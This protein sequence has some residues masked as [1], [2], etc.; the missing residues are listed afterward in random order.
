M[1]VAQTICGIFVGRALPGP[2][3]E[4]PCRE[5]LG[6]CVATQGGIVDV[7]A[8]YALE[9]TGQRDPFPVDTEMETVCPVGKSLAEF[10]AVVGVDCAVAVCVKEDK[11]AG[12]CV[13]L[14]ICF[15]QIIFL[16]VFVSLCLVLEYTPVLNP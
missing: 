10:R 9:I 16:V 12:A 6:R 13:I 3:V 14:G 2:A 7:I 5:V 4:H 15:R 11:V 1:L 8:P